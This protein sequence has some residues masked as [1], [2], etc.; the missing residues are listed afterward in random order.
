MAKVAPDI[1]LDAY[2]DFIAECDRMIACS[3]E[4]T[5]YAEATGTYALATQAMTP[6]DGNG[7]FTIA[8][9]TSGEK[10]TMTAKSGVTID[11]DGDATHVALACSSDGSLR[12]ITTCTQQTLTSGGTVDF[13]TW[14]INIAD[15]T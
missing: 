1:S 6:G 12:Y 10:L 11:D 9:D 7:D 3:A 5:T 4:P 13:P 15:P 14:K 8:P 2:L